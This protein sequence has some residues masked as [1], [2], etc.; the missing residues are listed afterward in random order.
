MFMESPCNQLSS[1]FCFA[2]FGV[3]CKKYWPRKVWLFKQ[4][5]KN[6]IFLGLFCTCDSDQTGDDLAKPLFHDV[7]EH[8]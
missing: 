1:G 8:T 3:M 4:N 5:S 6:G 2:S 7:K